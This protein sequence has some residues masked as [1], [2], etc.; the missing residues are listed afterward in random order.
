[1]ILAGEAMM[2]AGST[3]AGTMTL[4]SMRLSGSQLRVSLMNE[5]YSRGKIIG[6]SAISL[7]L[8]AVVGLLCW[9][10]DDKSAPWVI[11]AA[12]AL[13]GICMGWLIGAVVSPYDGDEAKEFSNYVKIISTFISGY[14]IAKFDQWFSQYTFAD[15]E[16][17]EVLLRALIIASSFLIMMLTTFY[18]RRYAFYKNQ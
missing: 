15:F 1:M 8:L 10:A 18:F 7:L 2:A 3:I 5:V 12:I 14:M 17:K 11:N 9:T 4:V 16:N 6:I 13:F